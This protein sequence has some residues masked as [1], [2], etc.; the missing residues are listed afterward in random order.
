MTRG[1]WAARVEDEELCYDAHTRED[2][3]A[4]ALEAFCAD[5]DAGWRELGDYVVHVWSDVV[6]H[7]RCDDEDC[8]HC[9]GLAPEH[10][11]V[12]VSDVAV[13][14]VGAS[15]Y[16]STDGEIAWRLEGD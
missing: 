12:I 9:A 14:S 11:A 5:V 4:S 2:A 15:V 16:E 7:E 10:G 1:P 8:D 6:W 13:P 3:I